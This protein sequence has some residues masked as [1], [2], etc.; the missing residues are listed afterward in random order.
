MKFK[1]FVKLMVLIICALFSLCSTSTS[2][3]VYLIGFDKT[4]NLDNNV[5]FDMLIFISPQYADDLEVLN[6]IDSYILTF[7]PKSV[8]IR[9]HL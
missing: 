7:N 9:L 5:S 2:V 1:P 3:S 4:L 6:A 8:F